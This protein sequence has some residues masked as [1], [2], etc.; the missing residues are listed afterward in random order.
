MKSDRNDNLKEA[1]NHETM[2]CYEN[3]ICLGRPAHKITTSCKSF[4]RQIDQ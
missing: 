4:Y 3:Q 1:M 2:T